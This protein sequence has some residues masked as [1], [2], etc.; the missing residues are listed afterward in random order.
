M[1]DNNAA[2]ATRVTE[3]AERVSA[4]EGI[5][6]IE[7]KVVGG[8]KKRVVQIF[9]D[10]PGGVTLADC[11]FVSQNV[12]TILD[13]EDVIPGEDSYTLE[14]SSPGERKLTKARDYELFTGRKIKVA[15]R[16]PVENQ[17]R[18]DGVLKELAGDTVSLEVE[19]G[20]VVQF[21]LDQISKANL[22]ID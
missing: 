4:S 5:R 1:P 20:R 8:G 15:L 19:P 14:V 22:K 3:I 10:K 7:V 11:E 17:Q 13:V 16:E 18:W 21:H 9:I 2:L 12:S 6:L